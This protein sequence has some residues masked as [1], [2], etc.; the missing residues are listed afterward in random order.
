MGDERQQA[1]GAAHRLERDLIAPAEHDKAAQRHA[2]GHRP[3]LEAKSLAHA[4]DAERLASAE[5]LGRLGAQVDAARPR[6]HVAAFE[7]EHV[8][9]HDGVPAKRQVCQR[10][11]LP[12]S[13]S[14]STAHAPPSTTNAP[15]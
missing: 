8:V 3:E 15:A 11:A 13:L 4:H 12:A 7:H 14:P 9:A 1:L 6:E 5:A 10:R 2:R